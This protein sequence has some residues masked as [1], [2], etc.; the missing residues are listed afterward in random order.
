MFYSMLLMHSCLSLINVHLIL[1]SQLRIKQY[2]GSAH[3]TNVYEV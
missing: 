1:V 3:I 2:T